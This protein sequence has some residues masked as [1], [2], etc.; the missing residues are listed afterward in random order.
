[1]QVIQS[2]WFPSSNQ[3]KADMETAAQ[4]YTEQS[5]PMVM[6][7]LTVTAVSNLLS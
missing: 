6:V 5:I 3:Q 1:V 4:V 7:L 2:Q